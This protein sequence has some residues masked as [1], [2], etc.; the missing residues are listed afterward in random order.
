METV[1][2]SWNLGLMTAMTTQ[3]QADSLRKERDMLKLVESRLSQEKESILVQQ[4][5]QNLLLTNLKS[6]QVLK[7]SALVSI[8][9]LPIRLCV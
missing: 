8:Y 1:H 2:D 9:W 6:I 5:S 3:S 7:A 4:K